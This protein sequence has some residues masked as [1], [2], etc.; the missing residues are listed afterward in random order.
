MSLVAEMTPEGVE[1][2]RAGFKALAPCP[3]VV[4]R[5]ADRLAAIDPAAPDAG[6]RIAAIV[7]RLREDPRAAHDAST[8]VW[9][10]MGAARSRAGAGG[11]Q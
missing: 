2:S 7:A 4:A 6:E 8:T 1:R 3:R 9:D 11:M 10:C 5:E